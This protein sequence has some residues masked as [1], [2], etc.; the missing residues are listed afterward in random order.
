MKSLCIHFLFTAMTCDPAGAASQA[1]LGSYCQYL[2][3]GSHYQHLP[4][5]SHYQYPL[6]IQ[7]I[8]G[9]MSEILLV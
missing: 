5:G 7:P 4:L 9:R 3:L 6:P 8:F 2:P 1:T